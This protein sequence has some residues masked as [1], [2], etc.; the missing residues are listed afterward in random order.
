MNAG[1]ELDALIAE[2]VMGIKVT[3]ETVLDEEGLEYEQAYETKN[4]KTYRIIDEVAPYSTDIAAAW[5]V[6][7]KLVTKGLYF[8]LS[9]GRNTQGRPIR[10]TATFK[11]YLL[12][13]ERTVN[14]YIEIYEIAESVPHAICLAALKVD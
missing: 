10:A 1:R 4:G 3:W 5:E 14:S 9:H 13:V 6:V 11:G 12:G 2:K 7:E 8:N